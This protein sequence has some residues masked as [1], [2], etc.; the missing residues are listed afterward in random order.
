MID[1]EQYLGL[2]PK[3]FGYFCGA[4]I[5]TAVI[6]TAIYCCIFGF[7]HWTGEVQTAGRLMT[8]AVVT[9]V[10]QAPLMYPG[11]AAAG[12]GV[13]GQYLCPQHGAVGLPNF[14]AAGAPHCPAC[15]QVMQ[16]CGASAGNL[17]PAAF[18]GG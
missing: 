8:A 11:Q 4:I 3:R 7:E 12:A 16:F 6:V 15:G 2:D 10:G 18:G 1:I 14:D 13:A 5:G 17:S 9:P